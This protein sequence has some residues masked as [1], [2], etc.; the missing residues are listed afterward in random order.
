MT[1]ETELLQ[2]PDRNRQVR[3]AGHARLSCSDWGMT[4]F[5]PLVCDEV[6]ISFQFA[7]T[8]SP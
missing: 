3:F 7:A 8:A 6:R 5:L 1:V 4:A 2:A